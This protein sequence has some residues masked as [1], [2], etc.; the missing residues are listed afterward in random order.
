MALEWLWEVLKDIE[1]ILSTWT[2][3]GQEILVLCLH[4]WV[5]LS[6]PMMTSMYAL[7]VAK[8]IAEAHQ[9]I[10]DKEC[11]ILLTMIPT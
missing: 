2:E 11:T 4:T 3:E 10:L 9:S 1:A 8:E 5:T 7:I 6:A